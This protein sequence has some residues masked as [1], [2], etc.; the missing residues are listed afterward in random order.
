MLIANGNYGTTVNS[1]GIAS[2]SMT[3]PASAP[4]VSAADNVVL[5]TS[6]GLEV[7]VPAGTDYVPGASLPTQSVPG[8]SAAASSASARNAANAAGKSVNSN[9]SDKTGAAGKLAVGS[10]AGLAA[11]AMVA[12]LA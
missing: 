7:A 8:G 9:E 2:A 1:A 4:A 12:L 5:T 11:F 3:L 10:F 6:G